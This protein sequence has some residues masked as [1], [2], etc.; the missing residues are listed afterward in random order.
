[1]KRIKENLKAIKS[2][3]EVTGCSKS[4][5]VEKNELVYPVKEGVSTIRFHVMAS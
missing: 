1:M 2:D 3:Y 5:I 4:R